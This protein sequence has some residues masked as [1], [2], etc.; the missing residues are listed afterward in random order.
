MAITTH[1]NRIEVF[2]FHSTGLVALC[3]EVA[4]YVRRSDPILKGA[5]LESARYEDKDGCHVITFDVD[6]D[7]RYG[8][9]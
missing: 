4:D 9:L 5:I 1:G 8:D 6:T 3:A 2:K 7:V